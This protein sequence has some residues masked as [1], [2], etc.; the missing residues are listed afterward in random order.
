MTNATKASVIAAVNAVLA[1]AVTLGL[2]LTT[3]Q[4]GAVGIALN[5]VLA[6]YVALTYKRSPKRIP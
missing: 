6:L 4:Y 3:D 5:A 1:A 2:P